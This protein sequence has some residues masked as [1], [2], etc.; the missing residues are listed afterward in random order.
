MG[1]MANVEDFADSIGSGI[2]GVFTESIHIHNKALF[3]GFNE[4]LN[5]FRKFK[6]RAQPDGLAQ[7]SPFN[8]YSNIKI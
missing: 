1:S 5:V 4:A 2:N 7:N 8:N 6:R 3:D